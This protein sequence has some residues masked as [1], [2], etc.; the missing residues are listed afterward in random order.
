MAIAQ[1]PTGLSFGIWQAGQH[2]GAELATEPGTL[3]WNE[4]QTRDPEAAEAFYRAVFSYETEIMDTDGVEY[5]VL[6]IDGGNVAGL[7]PMGED[8]AD[9]PPNWSTTFAVEDADNAVEKAKGAGGNGARAAVRHPDGGPLR[10]RPGSGRSRVRR[11]RR[12]TPVRLYL[13]V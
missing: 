1:D 3:A 8:M 9:V 11:H 12:L 7:M 2:H 10:R 13:S 4:C 5:R 6:K